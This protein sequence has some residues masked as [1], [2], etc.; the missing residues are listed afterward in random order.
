MQQYK[1]NRAEAVKFAQIWNHRGISVPMQDVHVD[2]ATDFANVVL[3]NFIDM[4]KQ[5]AAALAKAIQEQQHQLVAAQ[6]Q[7][8]APPIDGKPLIVVEG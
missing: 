7:Q 5:Q 2:F 3:R 6:Q 8:A 1:V 4:C